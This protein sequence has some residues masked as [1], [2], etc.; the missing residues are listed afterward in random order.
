MHVYASGEDGTR[1][2]EQVERVA[3][4]LQREPGL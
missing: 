4:F 2:R 3:G 1:I